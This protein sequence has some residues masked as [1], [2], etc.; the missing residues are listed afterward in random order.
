MQ[1]SIW[2]ILSYS[3]VPN[4]ADPSTF[5][6]IVLMNRFGL[7]SGLI[8]SI[9]LLLLFIGIPEEGWTIT[10]ILI[11]AASILFLGVCFLNQL[12]FYG[13]SRWIISWLPA[14][15]ITYISINDKIYVEQLVTIKDFFMYRFLLMT[16]TIIPLLVFSTN[17]IKVL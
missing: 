15:L 14:L 6:Y 17:N 10:R 5:R 4:D 3:G 8:T 16:T 7:I 13:L 1:L 2:N 9:I 11:L 12:G